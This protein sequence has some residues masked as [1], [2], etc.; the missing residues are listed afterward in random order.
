MGSDFGFILLGVKPIQLRSYV[1]YV[2]TALS[3]QWANPLSLFSHY[4]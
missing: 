4:P 3:A 2:S 1:S